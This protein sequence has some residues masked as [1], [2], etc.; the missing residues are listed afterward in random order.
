[1]IIFI[2][3]LSVLLPSA[4]DAQ[5]MRDLFLRRDW[6]GVNALLQSSDSLSPMDQS[7]AANAVWSANRFE[8]ALNLLRSSAPYWP[9]EVRPYGEFMMV[10]ALERLNSHAEARA[11]VLDLLPKAPPDLGY[12]VA[13]ALF[14]LT[15][16]KSHEE[17][18]KALQSMYS[19]AQNDAQRTTALTELLKL[20]GDRTAYALRLTDLSPRNS[21]AL[22]VLESL[23]KPWSPD[24]NMAVG[25][26]A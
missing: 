21:A 11:G 18:R 14:R 2:C 23:P 10:L 22:K 20:P 12:Y 15:D 6:R 13:Y 19:L 24:V 8:E 3:S 5:T 4:G 17:R 7:I 25:Y 1:M 16:E 9:D 26:A